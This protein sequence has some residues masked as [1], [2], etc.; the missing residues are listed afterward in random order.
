M[1]NMAR[2]ARGAAAAIMVPQVLASIHIYMQ[3]GLGLLPLDAALTV[4][5]VTL[6]FVIGSWLGSGRLIEGCIMQVIG[7]TSIATMVSAAAQPE[8]RWLMLPLRC[9]ATV[10]AWC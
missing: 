1:L 4:M 5:L 8:M 3:N 9:L 7:L 10:G 2:A 6:A